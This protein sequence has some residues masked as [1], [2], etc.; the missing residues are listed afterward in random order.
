MI[1]TKTKDI[2]KSEIKS[3]LVPLLI[4]E[5]EKKIKIST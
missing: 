3:I 4:K 5:I 2:N 1:N